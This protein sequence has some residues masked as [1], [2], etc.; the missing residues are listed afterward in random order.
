MWANI[1]L[2]S[3]LLRYDLLLLLPMMILFLLYGT[4]L[5]QIQAFPSPQFDQTLHRWQIQ[6]FDSIF[7]LKWNRVCCRLWKWKGQIY[8]QMQN[9]DRNVSNGFV[10]EYQSRSNRNDEKFY[11]FILF[12]VHDMNVKSQKLFSVFLTY[13]HRQFFLFLSFFRWRR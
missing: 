2:S 8:F 1:I 9:I 13:Y 12:F 7:F 11:T 6:Y 3:I 5:A 4:I 10:L